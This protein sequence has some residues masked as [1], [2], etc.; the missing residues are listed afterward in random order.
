MYLPLSWLGYGNQV[1]TYI[2]LETWKQLYVHHEYIPSR[3]QGHLVA[4]VLIGVFS[5]IGSFYLVNF[6]SILLSIVCLLCFYKIVLK[7][8]CSELISKL[9]ILVVATQPH[10]VIISTTAQDDIYAVSFFMLGLYLATNNRLVLSALFLALA[11][12]SRIVYG[13]MGMF[14]YGCFFCF[15]NKDETAPR[16]KYFISTLLFLFASFALFVPALMSHHFD[17]RSFLDHPSSKQGFTG[18]LVRWVYKNVYLWGLPSVILSGFVIAGASIKINGSLIR[19]YVDSLNQNFRQV[20]YLFVCVAIYTQVMF[21]EMPHEVF[22]LI[23]ML[24]CVAYFFAHFPIRFKIR[25]WGLFI[26]LNIV[27]SFLSIDIIE[28]EYQY[29]DFLRMP[30]IAIGADF[31]PHLKKGILVED[32]IDR[33]K[34]QAYHM[35]NYKEFIANL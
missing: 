24:F 32:V 3:G 29:K 19:G 33:S 35:K 27:Y 2:G 30:R 8:T 31:R 6:A 21:L 16:S 13:P 5:E 9:S 10:W 26:I 20:F 17:I 18:N 12:S 23:P 11:T 1:D 25:I 14:I 4:E 34:Y 28:I 22:Y 15:Q 7:T